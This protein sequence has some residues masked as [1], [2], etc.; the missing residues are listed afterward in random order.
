MKNMLIYQRKIIWL[1]IIL[2]IYLFRACIVVPIEQSN[3][4]KGK[5]HTIGKLGIESLL[6]QLFKQ[7]LFSNILLQ[8]LLNLVFSLPIFSQLLKPGNSWHQITCNLSSL[9]EYR[10]QMP[11]IVAKLML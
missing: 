9:L 2:K 5:E 3:L 4:L 1:D 10:S 11:E 8:E 6:I 7:S